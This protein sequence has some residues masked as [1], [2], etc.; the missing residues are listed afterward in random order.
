MPQVTVVGS[1]NVDLTSHSSRLPSPGE[2]IGE[3][4]FTRQAGCKGANQAVALSRLGATTRMKGLLE[5]DLGPNLLLTAIAISIIVG[6]ISGIYPG[7]RS[8][9]MSPSQ[10]LQA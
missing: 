8:S 1:I 5:P 9:R 7:W 3:G 2:T 10:A 4:A 6:V